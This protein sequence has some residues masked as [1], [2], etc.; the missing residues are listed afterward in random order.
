MQSIK[1]L[2]VSENRKNIIVRTIKSLWPTLKQLN[3]VILNNK[4]QRIFKSVKDLWTKCF[5]SVYPWSEHVLI[6]SADFVT[7]TADFGT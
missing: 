5:F 1:Q 7:T 6:L 3:N 4:I 2:W